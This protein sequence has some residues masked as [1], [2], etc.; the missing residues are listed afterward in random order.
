MQGKICIHLPMLPKTSCL[1]ASGCCCYLI[2]PKLLIR[3]KD[4][5][6]LFFLLSSKLVLPNEGDHIYLNA[7]IFP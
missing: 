4:F 2:F 5:K 3:Y 7:G 1:S 6:G